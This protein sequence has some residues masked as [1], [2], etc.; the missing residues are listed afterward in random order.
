MRRRTDA[1][2]YAAM[3]GLVA[4]FAFPLVWVASLSLKTGPEVLRSPPALLP[5]DPQWANYAHVLETTPI[6]RY[7]L[8][9]VILVAAGVAGA[10]LLSVPAAY[11]LSRF[12]GR[13][14]GPRAFTRAVLA[15]QLLSPLIIAV[16]VYRVFV[17]LGLIN[18]YVGLVLV[19]IAVTAPFLTWFLKNYLDTIPT[20]LDEAGR[21]DGCSRL[22]ALVLLVLPAA[23]PGLVSAGIVAGVT[24]WSQFVL[25]FILV[26]SP[27]LAPVSVGVVNLQSTSG[28]ITTQYLAAGC[29]LAVAPVIV[30]FAFLQRHIV[31]ALTAG[32]VKT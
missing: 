23:K 10:L 29:M 28:E 17:T 26:D 4:V 27:D 14:R 1:A 19:Y 8:N 13:M 12:R 5:Q 6:G 7:L 15:A 16:P 22:R 11:A 9:S 18:D 2:Y 3:L 30:V 20:E 32:A 24:T 31:G 21:V 25:P